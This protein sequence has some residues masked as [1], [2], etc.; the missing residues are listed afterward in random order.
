MDRFFNN[1]SVLLPCSSK[2]SVA[3][4]GY[5]FEM[6][7]F[8]L[9]FHDLL[10]PP[11]PFQRS[12]RIVDFSPLL[13]AK[14]LPI[15]QDSGPIY[16]TFI[17]GFALCFKVAFILLKEKEIPTVQRMM[18]EIRTL[19]N[20]EIQFRDGKRIESFLD[21]GGRFEYVLNAIIH[22]SWEEVSCSRHSW[23]TLSSLSSYNHIVHIN[24]NLIFVFL[25]TGSRRR[26]Q[27]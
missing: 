16:A 13:M 3:C 2:F 10:H 17:E 5:E 9:E 22:R 11:A 27:F 1:N 26:R 23:Y 14:Y 18:D 4:A 7:I 15:S 8:G 12:K 24:R 25:L 19:C 21:K 6:L 20:G